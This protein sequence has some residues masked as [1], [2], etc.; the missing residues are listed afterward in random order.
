M[1]SGT[2]KLNCMDSISLMLALASQN[3]ES[4]IK[5]FINV[6]PESFDTVLEK[7]PEKYDKFLLKSLMDVK[8]REI[9]SFRESFARVDYVYNQVNSDRNG[10]SN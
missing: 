7:W 9:K 6:L 1:N 2:K 5:A 4:S 3:T 10:F 8:E